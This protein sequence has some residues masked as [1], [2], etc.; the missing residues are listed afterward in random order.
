MYPGN[1]AGFHHPNPPRGFGK[2]CLALHTKRGFECFFLRPKF[3]TSRS[4]YKGKKK[5]E[6]GVNGAHRSR[7]RHLAWL[8]SCSPAPSAAGRP[9]RPSPARSE[10]SEKPLLPAQDPRPQDQEMLVSNMIIPTSHTQQLPAFPSILGSMEEGLGE[11]QHVSTRTAR[12][13]CDPPARGASGS[14][15]LHHHSSG[16]R[17]AHSRRFP[18]GGTCWQLELLHEA[19]FLKLNAHEVVFVVFW[20][21][22]FCF[23]SHTPVLRWESLAPWQVRLDLEALSTVI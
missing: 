22:F 19:N 7:T 21:G 8:L 10:G 18:C 4:D 13:K 11:L 5:K 17:C 16:C 20:F 6:K 3:F 15:V 2:F 14:S 9:S 1:R 12:L 23:P